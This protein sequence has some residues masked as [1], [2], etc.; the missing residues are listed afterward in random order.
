[1]NAFRHFATAL[2]QAKQAKKRQTLWDTLMR[3]LAEDL[4][5]ERPGRR[6][7][8]GQT[9]GESLSIAEQASESIS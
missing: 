8:R 9:P 4:V 7:P 5:P 1:M 3:T 2:A 6:E